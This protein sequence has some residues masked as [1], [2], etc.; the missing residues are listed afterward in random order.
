MAVSTEGV[1]V[2]LITMQFWI[3]FSNF[4]KFGIFEIQ[5][6]NLRIHR[7]PVKCVDD[8]QATKEKKYG[9]HDGSSIFK[10]LKILF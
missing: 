10:E 1:S 6:R 3:L 4:I 5:L 2:T 8:S 7:C 9:F